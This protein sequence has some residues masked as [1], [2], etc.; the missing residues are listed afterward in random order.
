MAKWLSVFI[1][2]PKIT[3]TPVKEINDLLKVEHQPLE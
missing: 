1:E 3:F 2:V